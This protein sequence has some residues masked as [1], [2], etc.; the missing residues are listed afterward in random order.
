MRLAVVIINWNHHGATWQR[1]QAIKDW[2]RIKPKIIIVDNGSSDRSSLYEQL[3]EQTI[4]VE[5][6]VN[7]GFAGGNN[8]GIT[9]AL[10]LRA[11]HVLLLNTDVDLTE[12]DVDQLLQ[13][14]ENDHKI[15]AIGPLLNNVRNQKTYAGGRD[16][17]LHLDT[18]LEWEP[19]SAHAQIYEVD[20]VP[21]T[22]FLTRTE[23]FAKAGLLDEQF[24]FG[25]STA[26]WCFRIR[27]MGYNTCI[28]TKLQAIHS[29]SDP[30]GLRSSL[31]VYYSLRNRFLFVEKWHQK[32]RNT[33]RH[34]W[35]Y[36]CMRQLIGALVRGRFRKSRAIWLAL[37]HG[38]K[39]VF[40]NQNHLFMKT[41]L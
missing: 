25:G 38:R 1:V 29:A 37:H 27:Q 32:K 6:E 10:E 7:K 41:G 14:L 5:S 19:T 2:K 18:R 23:L 13:S 20:Y 40:G 28:D 15:G 24:F 8:L 3:R 26:D 34:R 30:A 12:N 11:S 36:R 9:K 4:F 31:Y 22:V 39:G 16:L 35:L 17:A 21:G 33:L